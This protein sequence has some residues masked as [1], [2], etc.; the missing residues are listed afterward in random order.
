M[1]LS[2]CLFAG[3]FGLLLGRRTYDIFP[4]HWPYVEGDDKV[5]NALPAATRQGLARRIGDDDVPGIL[6][7]GKRL[8]ADGALPR[9]MRMTEHAVASA[10]NVIATYKPNGEVKPGSFVTI[11][12]SPAELERRARIAQRTW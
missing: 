1:A 9:A 11:K 7:S 6:G 10:G 12:A 2:F 5:R 8:L 4:A 3:D